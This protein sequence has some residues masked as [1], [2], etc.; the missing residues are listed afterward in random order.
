[1][2]QYLKRAA[3]QGDSEAQ[4]PYAVLLWNGADGP[5]NRSL[6]LWYFK[7]AADQ[8]HADVQIHYLNCLAFGRYIPADQSV[9]RPR[10]NDDVLRHP[11]TD[12]SRL[13]VGL[14]GGAERFLDSVGRW[15][16]SG[17]SALAFRN[18]APFGVALRRSED[19][20]V[21]E[22]PV[23]LGNGRWHCCQYV[24]SESIADIVR[25][26]FQWFFLS[27]SAFSS[28]F[29]RRWSPNLRLDSADF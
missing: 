1:V 29:Q 28:A 18:A 21:C 6:A 10:V 19:R 23:G 22:V 2:A 11:E 26:L 12:G 9:A 16:A 4:F 3:D 14:L 25:G 5:A 7:F 20:R 24:K 17:A 27:N 15:A 13:A 8:G